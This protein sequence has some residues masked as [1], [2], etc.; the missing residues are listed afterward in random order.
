MSNTKKKILIV[1]EFPRVSLDMSKHGWS[2]EA[3]HPRTLASTAT[4]EIPRRIKSKEFDMLWVELPNVRRAIAPRRRTAVLN[5]VASWMNA[6]LEAKTAAYLTGVRGRH[7]QEA[8]IASLA[9]TKQYHETD[10]ALCRFDISTGEDSGKKSSLQIHIVSTTPV[11]AMKCNC[12]EEVPH[13]HGSD[14][15]K[16]GRS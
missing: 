14:K 16:R 6:A 11:R 7:W 5:D 3:Y 4:A 9:S 1:E 13:E 12:G 2:V 8:P 10:F 15:I